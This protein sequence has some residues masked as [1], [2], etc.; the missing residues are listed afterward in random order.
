[1]IVG[2]LLATCI[3]VGAADPSAREIAVWSQK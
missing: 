1:M 3:T 2:F